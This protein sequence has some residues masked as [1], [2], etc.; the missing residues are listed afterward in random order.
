MRTWGGVSTYLLDLR[1]CLASLLGRILRVLGCLV[2]FEGNVLR[3]LGFVGLLVN[4][5]VS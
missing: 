4:A 5:L 1:L 3:G 2:V